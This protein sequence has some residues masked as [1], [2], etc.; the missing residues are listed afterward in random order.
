MKKSKV[1]YQVGY[2]HNTTHRILKHFKCNTTKESIQ[3]KINLV[4]MYRLLA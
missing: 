3:D 2:S 1:K 4:E